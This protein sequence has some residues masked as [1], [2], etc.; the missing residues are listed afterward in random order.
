MVYYMIFFIDAKHFI[1]PNLMNTYNEIFNS[2]IYTESWSKRLIVPI[3][4]KGEISDPNNYR[5]ITLISTFAKILSLILRN[6]LNDW[7]EREHVFNEFQFGFRNERSTS[8]CIFILN[9]LIQKTLNENSNLYC[10]F[11]D[12][13]KAFDTV[14]RDAIWFKLMQSGVSSKIVWQ[15]FCCYKVKCQYFKLFRSFSWGQA[16]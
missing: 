12:Y 14:N 8:D 5:G 4:K 16:G 6:R 1:V 3:H 2:G 15:S 7:C 10:A 11:V 13:E 9:S